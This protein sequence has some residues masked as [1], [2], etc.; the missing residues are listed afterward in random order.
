MTFKDIAKKLTTSIQTIPE[1]VRI[2]AE[3]LE[4]VEGAGSTVEVT[5]IISTGTKIA[6]VKVDDETTDLYAPSSSGS[7]VEI[8][9]IVSTGTK[10]ASVKVDDVTT[11]IYAPSTSGGGINYSTAEQDTGIKWI[12]GSTIY[13]KTINTGALTNNIDKT[14]AHGI[15]NFGM[16][17]KVEGIAITSAYSR[18]IPI[19]AGNNFVGTL[20]NDTNITINIAGDYAGITDSF[21][22][23]TY[24]KTT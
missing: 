7:T 15:S 2:L 5:Q 10:I 11:D 12:D 13:Q 3:G 14:V 22:T 20:I 8:T 21:V 6:S 4:K 16:I 19:V 18:T 17:I 1:L 23:L 9:Q 24:I